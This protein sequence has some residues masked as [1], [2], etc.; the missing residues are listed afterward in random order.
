M[1]VAC[2]NFFSKTC[3]TNN[4]F[5]R[6]PH[7]VIMHQKKTHALLTEN[8]CSLQTRGVFIVLSYGGKLS[9]MKPTGMRVARNFDRDGANNNQASTFE[10]SK[11]LFLK[12]H[13]WNMH[14]SG[15][16]FVYLSSDLCRQIKNTFT[17]SW[18]VWKVCF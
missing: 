18:Q 15:S 10:Y 17:W 5:S 12:I 9:W 1:C 11:P 2:Q 16:F 13:P 14:F 6:D 8:F 7:F 3:L 4:Y